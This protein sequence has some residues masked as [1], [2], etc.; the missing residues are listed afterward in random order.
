MS[1]ANPKGGMREPNAA[2]KGFPAKRNLREPMI[3]KPKPK[4]KLEG[5]ER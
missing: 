1:E 5:T 2:Q 4:A 3:G